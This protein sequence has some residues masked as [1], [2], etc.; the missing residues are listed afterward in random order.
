MAL[1]SFVW[2]RRLWTIGTLIS[3]S[4]TGLRH[5]GG[6]GQRPGFQD[7]SQRPRRREGPSGSPQRHREHHPLRPHRGHLPDHR[8]KPR[9][10]QTLV[11][12]LHSGQ[13]HPHLRLPLCGECN[14]SSLREATCWVVIKLEKCTIQLNL[15]PI[16]YRHFRANLC[17]ALF[18]HSDWPITNQ[19]A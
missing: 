3:N 19:N 8:A 15:D 11:Q 17:C 14:E 7:G 2:P 5:P 10:C 13:I 18:K 12:D 1:S 6:C 9:H 16:Q 4:S